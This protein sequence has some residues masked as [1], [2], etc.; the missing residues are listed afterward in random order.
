MLDRIGQGGGGLA[1]AAVAAALKRQAVAV[2]RAREA[3]QAVPGDAAQ[4]AAG[5]AAGAGASD[6][7]TALS[8]GIGQLNSSLVRADQLPV[9][10]LSGKVTDI[11][12][13]AA[14]LK[15]SELS[16]RFALEVRDKF[17]DAYREIMRMSV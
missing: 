16:L 2:A 15:E 17:I 3:A 5:S 10:V 9:D 7:S 12:E 4:R 8:Q 6:F 13:V 14:R 1:R 11:H